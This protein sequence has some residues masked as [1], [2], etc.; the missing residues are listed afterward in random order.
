VRFAHRPDP[1]VRAGLQRRPGS[2]EPLA[3]T[4]LLI[5]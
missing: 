1:A 2:A 3:R 4:S 5:S